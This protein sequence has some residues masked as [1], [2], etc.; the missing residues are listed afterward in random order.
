MSEEK[1]QEFSS[2]ELKDEETSKEE[3]TGSSESPDLE[4]RLKELEGQKNY[5]QEQYKKLKEKGEEK[6]EPKYLT[7]EEAK[8]IA[9]GMSDEDLDQLNAVAQGKGISLNEAKDD[10]LFKAYES[11]KEQESKSEKGQLGPST[12]SPQSGGGTSTREEH[13]KR[14]QE[15]KK[16]YGE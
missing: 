2:E 8:F 9:Q 12:A 13:M 3:E 5:Y 7:R 11:S 4:K 14:F 15:L 16:Q 6:E 10:P 1:E